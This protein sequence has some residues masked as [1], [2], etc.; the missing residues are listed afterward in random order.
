MHLVT[1]ELFQAG[2]EILRMF[3]GCE[4]SQTHIKKAP[5]GQGLVS[6]GW[7]PFPLCPQLCSLALA[8]GPPGGG[9]GGA[10]AEKAG[11]QMH[12]PLRFRGR[13]AA[14]QGRGSEPLR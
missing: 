6:P 1:K 13:A 11:R 8:V 2:L 12:V 10:R 3:K 9:G 14:A 5:V 4:L 7:A